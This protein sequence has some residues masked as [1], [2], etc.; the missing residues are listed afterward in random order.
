MQKMIPISI[1]N[2]FRQAK[3]ITEKYARTFYFSSLFLPKE[4]KYAAYCV[5]AICRISDESVDNTRIDNAESLKKIRD[6]IDAVYAQS[7]LKKDLL[8]AFRDT[9]SKYNIP[10]QYFSELID[11]M[12]MDLNKNS[13]DTFE[14]LKDYCYKVA[15]VVGLIMLKIFGYSNPKAEQYAVNLG[16]AMQLTNILRDIKEDFGRGRIYLPREEMKK[17][18]ISADTL[19]KEKIDD[20]FK[21]FLKFKISQAKEYYANSLAG[22][23]MVDTLYSRFVILAM[24]ELYAGILIDIEK[25][26]CD[27]FSRRAHFNLAQKIIVVSKIMLRGQYY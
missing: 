3:A 19:A 21:N 17:Y 15:G 9:V 10:K 4:K 26:D 2:G 11:G 14:E 12:Y 27:I 20:N 22:I 5:Y 13:Y 23:K 7:P 8:I 24:N 16:I 6:N 25:H 18:G 1:R